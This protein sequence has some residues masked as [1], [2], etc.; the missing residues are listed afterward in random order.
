MTG[1]SQSKRELGRRC[2]LC[3]AP[4]LALALCGCAVSFERDGGRREVV[5]LFSV[6][7]EVSAATAVAGS[8]RRFSFYGVWLDDAF[9]GT[10]FAVGEVQLAVAD[11][12]NHWRGADGPLPAQ[13]SDDDCA[14]GFSLQWCTLGAADPRRAGELFEI[15]VAGVTAGVGEDTRHFGVGYHKQM[16][17]E[18]TNANALVAWPA[19]GEAVS[20]QAGVQS[21]LRGSFN[22]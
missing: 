10:S 13:P 16:L 18:V 19:G 8:V 4:V 21:L 3:V 1:D 7:Q 15:A 5:G 17:I 14:V 22:G 20:E 2:A 6:A 9:R 12:R 11:L